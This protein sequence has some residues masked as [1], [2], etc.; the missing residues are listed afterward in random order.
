M[1]NCKCNGTPKVLTVQSTEGL[2]SLANVVVHVLSNNTTYYIDCARVFTIISSGPV[3]VDNY[4]ALTN[5]LGLANQVCYDFAA[6]VG[7]AF[8]A[9][10]EYRVFSLKEVQA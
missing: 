8:Q 1:N 10:N 3:F 5:P 6:N 2:K 9:P 4:D 7:Y